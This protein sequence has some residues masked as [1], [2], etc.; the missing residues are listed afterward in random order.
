MDETTTGYGP[1]P[2]D[3]SG[4]AW[5]HIE[6]IRDD[7]RWRTLAVSLG[8]VYL[9]LGRAY[10]G[11]GPGQARRATRQLV[12]ACDWFQR[13]GLSRQAEVAWRYAR[14]WRRLGGVA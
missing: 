1:A 12:T 14:R 10:V 13:A 4:S 3:S 2:D 8:D 11:L 5:A 7:Q 9:A 6:A